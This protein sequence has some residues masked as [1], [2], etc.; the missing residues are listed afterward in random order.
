MH[1]YLRAYMAGAALPTMIVPFVIA[2]I[3][4]L[5]PS[6]HGIHAEDV[7]IF[8]IGLAPNAWGLWNALRVWTGRYRDVPIGVFGL[9]LP[10]V[11]SPLAL[12]VQVQVGRVVWTPTLFAIGFPVTL[13]VYYL[14]WKHVVARF[15]A[16]LGVE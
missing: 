10:F 13:A 8:P 7:L 6:V 16:M 14:A 4:V 1:P 5:R 11:L 2:V 15:N 12:A 9:L 3:I